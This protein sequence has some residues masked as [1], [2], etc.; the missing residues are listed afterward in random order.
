MKLVRNFGGREEEEVIDIQDKV[1]NAVGLMEWVRSSILSEKIV[2]YSE[3]PSL[4]QG[5]LS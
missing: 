4:P 3:T 2:D 5:S 1:S